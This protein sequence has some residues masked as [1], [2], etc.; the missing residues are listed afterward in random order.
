[1]TYSTPLDT[2][3]MQP[4]TEI[5][6][7]CAATRPTGGADYPPHLETGGVVICDR[8]ADSTLAYRAMAGLDLPT[9]RMILDLPRADRA[10]YYVLPWTLTS[11]LA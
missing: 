11:R 3:E 10:G 1:V 4:R 7:Y 8:Y 5:L 2:R 9:L 6:L